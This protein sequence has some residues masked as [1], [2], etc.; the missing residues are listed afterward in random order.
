M[1]D[2]K[3]TAYDHVSGSDTFS[4][5]AA[6][7][8]SVAMVNRLKAQYPDEVEICHTNKDGFIM[9]R[10]PIEWMLIVP[11]RRSTMTEEQ[12]Q[13]ASERMKQMLASKPRVMGGE[14]QSNSD[15]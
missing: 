4:I 11:K 14:N 2:I 1:N 15:E 6:E 7:R 9:A 12:R 3:E 8:W 5:T 10:M 13:V